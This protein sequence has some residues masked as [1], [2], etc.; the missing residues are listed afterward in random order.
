M[1]RYGKA[2]SVYKRI[3]NIKRSSEK[4][5]SARLKMQE[6]SLMSKRS[7]QDSMI[8]NEILSGAINLGTQVAAGSLHNANMI[9][10]G[11]ANWGS[12][13]AGALGT[14]LAQSR[15]NDDYLAGLSREEAQATGISLTDAMN[16]GLTNYNLQDSIG[17]K[18]YLNERDAFLESNEGRIDYDNSPRFSEE[19]LNDDYSEYNDDDLRVRLYSYA[20]PNER[21]AIREELEFR[22]NQRQSS[23]GEQDTFDK[24]IEDRDFMQRSSYIDEAEEYA[25]FQRGQ[26]YTFDD[27]DEGVIENRYNQ[28]VDQGSFRWKGRDDMNHENRIRRLADA[29]RNRKIEI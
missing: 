6:Q 7:A 13:L 23:S 1:S 18:K 12:A 28:A 24:S 2:L 22:K 15:G 10:R 14:T 8:D 11:E 5:N 25:Q 16:Q 20:D 9:S 3:N 19:S 4:I 27:F 21:E 26:G 29:F 17:E